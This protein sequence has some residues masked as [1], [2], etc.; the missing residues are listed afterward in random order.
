MK[1]IWIN[2]LKISLGKAKGYA[3]ELRLTDIV[4][5]IECIEDDLEEE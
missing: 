1:S 4:E 2:Q 3:E 5:A